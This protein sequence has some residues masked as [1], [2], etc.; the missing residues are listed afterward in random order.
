[1]AEDFT[2]APGEVISPG[3]LT[4]PKARELAG[5]MA[6]G[7]LPYVRFVESRRDGDH[8]LVV[9]DV[10]PE[11]PQRPVHDIRRVERIA[12]RFD[13]KD[14]LAPDPLALRIDFP[15]VP[16]TNFRVEEHPRSLCLF[17]ERYEDQKPR[18]TAAMFAKQLHRWLSRTARGELHESDQPL[19]PF[20]VGSLTP[21]VLPERFYG[22]ERIDALVRLVITAVPHRQN[23]FA[24]I[25]AE[26][27]PQTEGGSE[28]P[29][30]GMMVEGEPRTHGVI[31]LQPT[32]LGQLHDYLTEV[33]YDLVGNLKAQIKGWR[34]SDRD[35]LDRSLIL[36][37]RLPKRRM[38]ESA[39]ESV[40]VW[41]FATL[42]DLRAIGQALGLWEVHAEHLI[43]LIGGGV[44]QPEDVPLDL[45]NPMSAFT[46]QQ[47]ASANGLAGPVNRRI[48]SVGAGALGSQVMMNLMRSGYGVWTIVDE[49]RLLPHNLA[50]HELGGNA[51]AYSKAL[52]LSVVANGLYNGE[53]IAKAI[54]AD[55]L[56]PPADDLRNAFSEAEVVLDMSASVTVARHLVHSVDSPAR[57]VSLFL[58]PDGTDLVLLA[59]DGQRR[60][61]LDELEMQYY[62]EL[63]HRSELSR[64]LLRNGERIRYAHGCRD[65]TASISQEQVAVHAGVGARAIRRVVESPDATLAIWKANEDL[66]ISVL[67]GEPVPYDRRTFGEWTLSLDPRL[68]RA[69]RELRAAKLPNETGGV[70]LGAFDLQ[71]KVVYVVDT[72]PSPPDSEEWPTLY[73]RGHEGLREQ[74]EAVDRV[75]GGGLQYVGEWHSHPEGAGCTPSEDDQKVFAW[76]SAYMAQ[77]GLP[78]LMVIIGSQGESRWIFGAG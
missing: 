55:V 50:R 60:V 14:R 21:I 48:L 28:F 70:L 41:A 23:E 45:L 66:G 30:M 8:E 38:D 63:V 65:V 49:D 27:E 20:F 24:F 72:I 56:A 44:T 59:E 19:E 4:I 51:V 15:Q 58:N 37:V 5:V 25:A 67:K 34:E 42:K 46:R 69:L 32:N 2:E 52:V 12:V 36:I 78:P 33:G 75:T 57:R 11:V 18:W 31:R 9:L 62:R 47:A 71:R 7:L 43:D 6:S 74:V 76:L 39:P 61:R 26:G 1:M 35:V 54:V 10:E 16:H 22:T 68:L 29:F 3:A 13:P 64:H 40:D 53:T 77:D 17:E 73:I